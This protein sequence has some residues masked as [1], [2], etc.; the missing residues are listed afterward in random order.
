MKNPV[1]ERGRGVSGGGA[2]TSQWWISTNSDGDTPTLG[3]GF[4]GLSMKGDSRGLMVG[5]NIARTPPQPIDYGAEGEDG[6]GLKAG[7]ERSTGGQ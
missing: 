3:L 4:E 2:T 1:A 5:G 6:V 7:C